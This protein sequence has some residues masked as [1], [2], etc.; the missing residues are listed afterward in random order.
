MK[1]DHAS[2]KEKRQ[3]SPGTDWKEEG[4][5]SKGPCTLYKKDS[6]LDGW[7]EGWKQGKA[8][9]VTVCDKV[10]LQSQEGNAVFV[11]SYTVCAFG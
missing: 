2:R 9:C 5:G 10:V 4:W 11:I 6:V 7:T 3:R 1:P 8:R